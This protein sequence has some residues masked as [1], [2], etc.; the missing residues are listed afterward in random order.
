MVIPQPDLDGSMDRW[1]DRWKL[2]HARKSIKY[3][4]INFFEAS[5]AEQHV[6]TKVYIFMHTYGVQ[7]TLC[8]L[9]RYTLCMYECT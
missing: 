8:R 9:D 7:T 2:E 5:Y 3:N 4:T 1:K 6:V